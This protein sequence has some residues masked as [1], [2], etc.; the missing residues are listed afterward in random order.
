MPHRCNTSTRYRG[1]IPPHAE[2]TSTGGNQGSPTGSPRFPT[3][4]SIDDQ[5]EGVSEVS[6]V[7]PRGASPGPGGWTYEHLKLLLEDNDTVELLLEAVTSLARASVPVEVTRALMSARLTALT[8]P[9]GGICGIA[10]RCAL[11]RLV[12]RIFARQRFVT[13]V[14]GGEQGDP[15]MPLLFSIGIHG[16]LEEVASSM[17]RGEQLCAFLDDIY[18]L[19]APHRVVPLFKQLSESL[20]RVAGSDFTKGKLGSGAQEGSLRKMSSNS[21]G[22]LGSHTGSKFSGPPWAPEL[23]PPKSCVSVWQ[24]K[25]NC[26]TPSLL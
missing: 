26:G 18:V 5:P 4:H 12:A 1:D 16:A 23:S 9:D 11:R 2:Q 20:E 22:T 17:E 6:E 3:R 21:G 15:L 10:T 7:R 8:K 19:F 13:Q 14:E 24:R 25:G